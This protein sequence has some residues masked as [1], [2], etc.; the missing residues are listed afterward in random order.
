MRGLIVAVSMICIVRLTGPNSVQ[1]QMDVY[2]I[3]AA[4]EQAGA[5]WTAA[6]NPV[7]QLPDDQRRLLASGI[8]PPVSNQKTHEISARNR[9]LPDKFDWRNYAGY[10]WMTPVKNQLS[11]GSCAAFA[12][13]GFLEAMVKIYRNTPDTDV[14]LS[15]QHLF[16]CADGDCA[17]G[18][19][20]GDALDYVRD[21]GVPDEAC[22]PYTG[23]DDN[24]DDTCSDWMERA[25]RIDDW[26]LL[27]QYHFDP[28]ALKAYIL[29]H[30]MPCYMEVY[31]DFYS[32]SSGVYQHVTGSFQGGHFV[33]LVGWEDARDCWICKNSWGEAWGDH[34]YF[35]IKRGQ[36]NIGS[37]AMAATYT[38]PGQTPSPQ[39]SVSQTP[40]P[41][42]T[43]ELPATPTPSYTPTA[44]PAPTKTATPRTSPTATPTADEP[45][46]IKI[47]L[48]Q[49]EF[50][51]GDTFFVSVAISNAR[52]PMTQIPLFVLLEIHGAYWFWPEW[53]AYPPDISFQ[54]VDVP[55][56]NSGVNIIDPFQWPATDTSADGLLFAA[57]LVNQELTDIL[58][59]VDYFQWGYH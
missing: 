6:E 33:V 34:G 46:R 12:A 27:W 25:T 30:P 29:E 24:C 8:L 42:N 16:S 38:E 28:E 10:D 57:A 23:V 26:S 9:R 2:T 13:M 39:P 20:L 43:P 18:L 15:E 14:D 53:V 41:T 1:A 48:P 11:C 40:R 36:V 17:T 47:E 21:F 45:L 52:D 44:P 19:Y 22:L 35:R 37:W 5:D 50:T 58:C 54:P 4:I 7:I 55:S 31:S 51:T 3:Q 49:S 56:G 59:P 32:Y